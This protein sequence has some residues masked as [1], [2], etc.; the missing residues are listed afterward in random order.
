MGTASTPAP[1]PDGGFVE[2]ALPVPLDQTFTYRADPGLTL[3]PGM[4][5]RVPWGRR[6]LVGLVT[7]VNSTP[8]P[9]IEPGQIR[10]VAAVI[11]GGPLLD[12]TMLELVRWAAVYY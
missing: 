1:A 5:V 8:P 10:P 11:E 3:Q 4:A 2:V 6:H 12:A 9:G 7:E